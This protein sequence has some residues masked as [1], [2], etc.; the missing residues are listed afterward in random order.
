VARALRNSYEQGYLRT[1]EELIH[2]D[3]FADFLERADEL[4][5]KH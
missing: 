1:V 5:S 3:L 2:A 4:V